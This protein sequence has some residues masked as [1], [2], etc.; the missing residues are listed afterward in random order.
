MRNSRHTTATAT[1]ALAI[2]N[3]FS[4]TKNLCVQ[5]S[6][7]VLIGILKH[8]HTGKIVHFT[9]WNVRMIKRKE[10]TTHTST[11]RLIPSGCFN[12]HTRQQDENPF[13]FALP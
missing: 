10:F 3:Y 4:Q 12:K 6:L 13:A 9:E 5:F 11:Y 1:A 2:R 7:M 8:T